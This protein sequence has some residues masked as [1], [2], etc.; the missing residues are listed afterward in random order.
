MLKRQSN[1]EEDNTMKNFL[2]VHGTWGGGWQWRQVAER[3]RAVGHRVFTPTMTGLGERAHLITPQ[4]NL[5]THIEDIAAVIS[6]EKLDD[7][8]LVG[9]SYAGLVISGVADRMPERIGA[10]IYLNA[11]LPADGKCMLDTVSAERRASVQKLA[12]AEGD[13]YRV[14]SSLVLDTGIEDEGARKEFLRRMSFHPLSSLLQP[15]HLTGR[16]KEVPRKAYVLATKKISHHF[17]EYYD[18][19]KQQPDWTAHEIASQHYP[20][21]TAPDLT[22]DLLMQIGK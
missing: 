8:V 21:A 12:D 1:V 14:P 5:D 6:C 15:I 17:Q 11:A 2:L 20:M 22:A 10:L 19:A 3:I 18:W 9:T 4:T 16:Y 13:G 7:V